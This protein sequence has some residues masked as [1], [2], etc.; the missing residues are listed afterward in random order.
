VLGGFLIEH[1]SWHWAFYVN[2]PVG[3]VAFLFGL[4]FLHEHKEPEAGRFDLP[5]FLLAGTG[6][7]LVMYALSTGPS[8]GWTSPR[9]LGTGLV[10]ALVL[11]V[12]VLVELRATQPMIQLRLLGNRLF[13]TTSL[14]TLFGSAGFIGVLFLMPLFLQEVRG[15]SPLSSG[16]TT[17]PEAIGVVVST[18]LVA[19]LYPRIGP[20][21]LMAGGLVGVATSMTL[22]LL[23]DLDTS[24]WIIRLLMF[25]IGVGM[26]YVFLPSQAA[27]FATISRADT[28]RAATLATV[29]RQLGSALGVALLSTVL[30]LVGPIRID[31]AGASHPNLTAYHVAFLVSACLAIVAAL[32]ALDVPDRDAANTMRPRRSRRAEQAQ[33]PL[34]VDIG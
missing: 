16:L 22:L 18:Q 2:I 8:Q 30:A 25:M 19:R 21:R 13:R 3:V 31:A 14:V 33:E 12:F 10:G 26:A 15:A 5:G 34:V 11:V 1:F 27:S 6:F 29:Q 4:L 9:I 20:R 28:G 24:D 32:I 17:F 7:A 23:V